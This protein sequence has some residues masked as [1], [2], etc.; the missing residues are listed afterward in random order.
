MR[1]NRLGR[2]TGLTLRM[3][4]SSLFLAALYLLFMVVLLR[5]GVGFVPML[6][7]AG[8]MLLVQYYFSDQLVLLSVGARVVRPE[9]EPRLF[10][11]VERL[12]AMADIPKPKMAVVH[13]PM[14]NAFATGRDP[15][16]AV[17]AVTTGLLNSL[18]DDELEAVLAHEITHI[19]N[20]DMTLM[21]MAMFFAT[22]ASFIVQWA[23][24]FLPLGGFGGGY[25]GRQERDNAALVYLVSFLVY[26]ISFFLIRAISRYRE[27][28]ADRGS[29]I[30]TGSP[31]SLMSAL[32]KISR[33]AGRIPN[34]DLRQMETVSALFIFPAVGRGSLMELF[35][36]HPTLEHRLAYLRRIEAELSRP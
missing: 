9:E 16:H 24:W 30:L 4:I 13:M 20:R 15:N 3:L 26:I 32:L 7:I 6:F 28:A 19:K 8:G 29:A 17:V 1:T 2:D 11:M 10:A 12:A 36:T 33:T 25:G 18:D 35:Q 5:A 23:F 14:A 34:R 27:Y 31:A 21:T 22:L